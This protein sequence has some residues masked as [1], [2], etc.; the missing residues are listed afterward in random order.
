MLKM[1]NFNLLFVAFFLLISNVTSLIS[2]NM[3]FIENKGQ[4]NREILYTSQRQGL[5]TTVTESGIYFDFYSKEDNRIKGD[6]LKLKLLNSNSFQFTPSEISNEKYNYFLGNDKSKWVTNVKSYATL[7]AKDVYEGIDFVYYTDNNNPRYDFIVKPYAHPELINIKFDGI[8]EIDLVNRDVV[9]QSVNNIIENSSLLAYQIVDGEKT[10]IECNFRLKNGNISFELGDYDRSKELI[11]DPV[12]YSSYFGGNG[13]DLPRGV[14]YID[15]QNF[16]LVGS[17]SSTDFRTTT[18]A[19]D[20]EYADR[21]DAFLTKFKIVNAEYIPQFTTFI[22]SLEF[23]EAIDIAVTKNYILITGNTESPDFPTLN[24]LKSNH[25]G[26]KD[27]FV[28]SLSLDGDSLLQSTLYGGANDDYVVSV[29]KDRNNYFT[30]LAYTKSNDIPTS[31]GPPINKYKGEIDILLFSL[32]PSREVVN[33]STYLG[34]GA[35]DIPTYLFIDPNTNNLYITG[36]TKSSQGSDIGFPI[37]PTKQFNI[38]GPYDELYNG[39]K[40]AFEIVLTSDAKNIIISGFLGGDGDDIGRG[41]WSDN[42]DNIYII[43]E[44]YNNSDGQYFPTTIGDK[45]VSGNSDIFITKFNKLK[46]EWF[47]GKT[48]SLNS[49]KLI[50]SQGNEVI[51]DFKNHPTLNKFEIL[52]ESE[53]RFPDIDAGS[54]K[55]KKNIVFAGIDPTSGDLSNSRL[56]GTNDDDFP[57]SFDIDKNGNYLIAGY[58][59]SKDFA[60]TVNATQNQKA[61]G[62]DIVLIRNS[63]SQISL[64]E[65][66]TS[67]SLCVGSDVYIVWAGGELLKVD[68]GYEVAYSIDKEHNLFH[69]IASD[70][71]KESYLWTVPEEISGNDSLIIR[72]T[73]NS[74]VFVQN[75][76]FFKVNEKSKITSF[77]LATSDTICIGDSIKFDVEATG[78]GITYTWYKDGIEIEKSDTN[79]ITIKGADFEMAGTYKVSVSSDCPPATMSEKSFTIYVSPNTKVDSIANEIIKDKGETLEITANAIGVD[80]QYIWQKDGVDLP[81]QEGNTLKLSNLSLLDS[82]MYRC[83]VIGK[84]GVDSTNEARVVVKTNNSVDENYFDVTKIATINEISNNI[85]SIE[86]NIGVVNFNLTLYN[87]L[88]SILLKN[89]YNSDTEL[90]LNNYSNGVYWLVIKY[91]D[92]YYRTKLLKYN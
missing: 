75:S 3:K 60:T 48:Q 32:L 36:Y 80:L 15:T 45:K 77:T 69:T 85:Y 64:I 46:D 54:M 39:R 11:I 88:G 59:S 33:Y 71:K 24:A 12:I 19:Y 43:G 30:F 61:A 42:N 87:N 74:G 66:S 56:Y 58:T 47:G 52:V 14:K 89:N 49:S 76:N 21:S 67:N 38:G 78:E 62:K 22:G 90:N 18:G 34:G 5:N 4:W 84:C 16:F 9:I 70:V 81:A 68:D 73:H 35:D 72:V 79:V 23:D 29:N 40:D 20:V 92:K 26:G 6:V 31:A 91:K 53:G 51:V 13:D 65:P 50:S 25:S 44:T 63:D 7:T 83:Y 82:G 27:I 37:Y 41:I 86:L 55:A 57:V 1:K 17:T 28:S 2:D 8:Q 10:E